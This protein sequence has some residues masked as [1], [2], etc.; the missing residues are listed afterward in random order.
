MLDIRTKLCLKEQQKEAKNGC[1]YKIIF[2]NLVHKLQYN[3]AFNS[4]LVW[5]RDAMFL[6]HFQSANS[7]LYCFCWLI[8][9][10][11]LLLL[12]ASILL[13]LLLLVYMTMSL[14]VIWDDNS[15]DLF[16][17]EKNSS[18]HFNLREYTRHKFVIIQNKASL[19]YSRSRHVTYKESEFK[20][21]LFVKNLMKSV[22]FVQY[23]DGM[24][25][26]R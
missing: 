16:L 25:S 12:V 2:G 19:Q 4:V 10:L 20:C 7:V 8:Y 23:L 1:N 5:K 14:S 21:L 22:I 9:C 13:L 26:I 24:N 15:V 6:Q 18:S 11:P 3:V 17:F